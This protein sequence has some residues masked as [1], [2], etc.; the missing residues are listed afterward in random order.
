MT[1]GIIIIGYGTRTGNLT[2]IIERQAAR[3]RA[4]GI[5][6]VY[7]AYFR[8]SKPTIE[9]ALKQ[10]VRD[11]VDDILG[12]PYYIAEGT[13]TFELIPAK[14]G[15]TAGSRGVAEVDGKK[16]RI[17]MAPAFGT[18]KVLTNFLT[19]RIADAGGDMDTGILVLGHGSRDLTS[20]NEE[21]IA[22][23]ASRLT[24]MGYKNV[25]Y[26]FNEFVEPTIR[27]ALKTLASMGVDRIIAI[28]LFI[29]SGVH[30][31]EEI[32]EQLGIP[33]YSAGGQIEV[34]G[35]KIELVYTKPVEDDGRI[36]DLLVSKIADFRGE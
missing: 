20:S 24:E 25:V 31:G 13:L 14:L 15:L 26:S 12:L 23:N 16:V 22:L 11:G 2:E 7:T 30:L 19:D 35:R 34:S 27:D 28:P 17:R 3:I 10:A 33:A 9:D 32:P 18:S 8:V 21:I 29:A 6:N 5:E 1:K 36:T 4:R